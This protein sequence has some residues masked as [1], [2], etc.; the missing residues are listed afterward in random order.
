MNHVEHSH[1][2]DRSTEKLKNNVASSMI[3]QISQRFDQDGVLT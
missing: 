1:A 2:T 3:Y